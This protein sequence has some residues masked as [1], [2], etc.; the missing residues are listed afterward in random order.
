MIFAVLG[1]YEIFRRRPGSYS[2]VYSS[3]NFG[4]LDELK[5]LCKF[6][7]KKL[8][9]KKFL[10]SNY[11]EDREFPYWYDKNRKITAIYKEYNLHEAMIIF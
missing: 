4:I 10:K 1:S 9:I 6:S 3:S 11:D 2:E 7:P 8:I 5:Y